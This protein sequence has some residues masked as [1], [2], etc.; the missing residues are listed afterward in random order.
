MDIASQ[1][2]KVIGLTCLVKGTASAVPQELED[3]Q[4]IQRML[5]SPFCLRAPLQPC[6]KYSEIS[7]ALAPEVHI[8]VMS[9]LFSIL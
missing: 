6:R 4:G 7:G 5:K 8:F 2:Q 3:S 9:R 1:I